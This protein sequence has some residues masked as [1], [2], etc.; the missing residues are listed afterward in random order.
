MRT[1]RKA[2]HLSLNTYDGLVELKRKHKCTFNEIIEKFIPLPFFI[3]PVNDLPPVVKKK[4]DKKIPDKKYS[5]AADLA[6]WEANKCKSLNLKPMDINRKCKAVNGEYPPE[7]AAM[8]AEIEA[9]QPW[10][11]KYGKKKD[12]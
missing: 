10:R 12:N 3:S 5:Y 11:K 9:G 1:E 7:T 8:I 2:I 6:D 4:V